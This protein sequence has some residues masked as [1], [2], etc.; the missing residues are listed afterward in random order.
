MFLLF[1]E[2]QRRGGHANVTRDEGWA[3]MTVSVGSE[4]RGLGLKDAY[5]RYL[6]DFE[7]CTCIY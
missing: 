1:K 2:V 6:S 5:H 7:V 4:A 3:R